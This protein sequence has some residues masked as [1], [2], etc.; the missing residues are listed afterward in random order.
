MCIRDR[1]T[2]IE[3]A[4]NKMIEEQRIEGF[5]SYTPRVKAEEPPKPPPQP[6]FGRRPARRYS[7]R[8]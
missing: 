6:V 3:K 2:D 5:T 7:N 1:L 4:I 8:L